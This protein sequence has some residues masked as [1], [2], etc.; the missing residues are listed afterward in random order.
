MPSLKNRFQWVDIPA[1]G[2]VCVLVFSLALLGADAVGSS[3]LISSLTL[4]LFIVSVLLIPSMSFKPWVFVYLTAWTALVAVHYLTGRTVDAE[5]E[6]LM[7]LTG[8]CCFWVGRYSALTRRRRARVFRI[9]SIFS[10]I[11]GIYSIDPYSVLAHAKLYH[12]DRLTGTF[13]SANTM[14]TFSGMLFLFATFR[15]LKRLQSEADAGIGSA[16]MRA[17]VKSPVS[18]SAAVTLSACILLTGS[19]AGTFCVVLA[20]AVLFLAFAVLL[21]SDPRSKALS[22]PMA[23]CVGFVCLV[24][25][26][27][28]LWLL[29]GGGLEDR[30]ESM[31]D[32]FQGRSAMLAAS[33]RAGVLEPYLGH[34]LDGLRYAKLIVSTPST[35]EDII[36]QNA[37]HNLFAQWFVQAGWPGLVGLF[38]VIVGAVWR[39]LRSQSSILTIGFQLSILTLV[40]VHG[41]FDYALEI[42]SVFLLLSFLVGLSVSPRANI[43]RDQ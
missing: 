25:A 34:G 26:G 19:R 24:G 39:C 15:F 22:S 8:G 35:N 14:A 27:S 30:L 4:S 2:F 23:M 36:S 6:Y 41:L 13:L 18:V 42:P 12:K 3:L 33:W 28:A 40:L 38:T 7:L 43:R 10:L 17:A 20:L 29:W 32:D 16:L 9:L 5:Q 21:R 1:L 11:F 31:D 37:A